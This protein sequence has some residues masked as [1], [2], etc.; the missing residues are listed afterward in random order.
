MAQ[1]R[2]IAHCLSRTCWLLLPLLF[3]P[4]G[5]LFALELRLEMDLPSKTLVAAD[6]E[7]GFSSDLV[8]LLFFTLTATVAVAVGWWAGGRPRRIATPAA[9]HMPP[10]EMPAAS[11]AEEP[12]E[13]E[14]EVVPPA[15]VPEPAQPEDQARAPAAPAKRKAKRVKRSAAPVEFEDHLDCAEKF[16]RIGMLDESFEHI[17]KGL[18][19]DPYN[20]DLYR[21]ALR[22]YE[23]SSPPS[24][25]LVRLL[26]IGIHL[27]WRRHPMLWWRLSDDGRKHAPDLVD[28]DTEP[29]ISRE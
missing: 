14:V 5:D 29:S 3:V 4:L 17:R 7:T 16:L 9:E 12:V 8:F 25:E 23:A 24:P 2:G 11:P 18:E 22:L 26:K 13:L 15:D 27:L 6:E 19:L 20:M 21:L 28:W 1:G 10:V